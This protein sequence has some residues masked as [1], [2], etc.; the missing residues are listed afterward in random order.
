MKIKILEQFNIYK[1]PSPELLSRQAAFPGVIQLPD[2]NLLAMFAIG[3]A[4]ES[5]DM[6]TFVS[7]SKDVGKTWSEPALI[8][9][10]EQLKLGY[11][12]SECYKPTLLSNGSIVA[13]GYGFQRPKPNVPIVNSVAQT[14]L[15]GKNMASISLNGGNEW[16]IPQDM[17][18][19]TAYMLEISGPCIQL[20]SGRLVAV[21][22]EFTLDPTKQC[23]RV[24]C[25][26][27]N[28]KTWKKL[29][30]YCQS[31]K[32]NIASWE[33]RICQIA[34]DRLAIIFWAYDTL[35]QKH[36]TNQIVVSDDGGLSWSDFIDTGIMAQ[37][38][39]MFYL[40]DNKLLTIHAHRAENPGLYL[41]LAKLKN[42]QFIVDSETVIWSGQSVQNKSQNI[43]QQF[44]SLRFGQ[45]SLVRLNDG[46]FLSAYW[47]FEDCI[48]I[49]KAH[50]LEISI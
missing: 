19:D 7:H 11:E 5:A 21:G 14:F 47:C 3:Q 15:P 40:G 38:S 35:N 28:G 16:E 36:L 46:S 45:P 32:G 6:R 24:V 20:K 26:D 17:S 37:A 50:R 23:G 42:N 44:A 25:S 34:S 39:N 18:L 12:L 1:N 33:S 31:P 30:V 9:N 22:A 27:D 10:Q 13:V 8:Y 48:Y 43:K 41:R 29:S 4:F 2:G 49:I